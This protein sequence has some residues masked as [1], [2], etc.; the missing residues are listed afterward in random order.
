MVVVV[1]AVVVSGVTKGIMC[2]TP[3]DSR[4]HVNVHVHAESQYL[5]KVIQF[6]N[7]NRSISRAARMKVTITSRVRIL[8]T[9]LVSF[10]GAHVFP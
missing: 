3:Q 7:D 4:R 5:R 1:V 6:R 10:A 8:A 2:N 9:F